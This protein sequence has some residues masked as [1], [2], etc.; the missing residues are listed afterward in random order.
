MMKFKRRQRTS[1]SEDQLD[2]L[3]KVFEHNHYPEARLRDD[4]ARE[5]HLDA[6][7]IQ[8]WFQNQRA[9]DRKRR[10]LLGS[11]D[12][13]SPTH[14]PPPPPLRDPQDY[15]NNFHDYNHHHRH[16]QSGAFS[17]R[18]T[19]VFVF[20][21]A[22]ANEAAEAV[23]GGRFGSIIDFHRNHYATGGLIPWQSN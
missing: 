23:L 9:K 11:D 17:G 16:Q 6:S 2:R 7:R 4:L 14:S 18:R 13:A 3:N 5:T 12:F 10:G 21:S 15:A 1:F 8:V 19:K 20:N 22:M